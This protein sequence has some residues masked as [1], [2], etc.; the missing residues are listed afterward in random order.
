MEIQEDKYYNKS[1]HIETQQNILSECKSMSSN[2]YEEDDEDNEDED[3]DECEDEND[4][5]DS[6][7]EEIKRDEE[8]T[9]GQKKR[10]RKPKIKEIDD[11]EKIPKKRG[12]KPKEKVYSVKELPKTFFE[13]NKNEMLILHLPIKSVDTITNTS[14]DIKS[15][16]NYSLYD[17]NQDNYKINNEHLL[18]T[19]IDLLDEKN[20]NFLEYEMEEK[21]DKNVDDYKPNKM[22]KKNLKNI[23]Y[24]F[25][26]A[27]NEKKWPE[28]TNIYCW[29]C[30]HPFQDMPCA[31]PEN[32]SKE[33]FYVFG[34]FCSFN[35]TAAYN[36]SKNDEN[37]WERYTLLNLMYKK[38]F[39]SNFV[40]I[41][42]APVRESLKIFGGYL[43]IEEFRENCLKNDKTLLLI[44]PPL[45]SII[46]KIEENMSYKNNKTNNS[47]VNENIL[48]KTHTSLKLKRN[49]PITNPNNTLQSFM[50]LKII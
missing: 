16:A 4:E 15:D 27:N 22:F 48:N 23:M 10:G 49:K 50:D 1:L 44:K 33:K 20:N 31:L 25:V 19:Q 18:Q 17:E 36:F 9:V 26:N 41:S 35:C 5:E 37:M 3:E 28:T 8:V 11:N 21:K 38:L 40:K 13:E 2:V 43:S 45:I 24:Q 39:H 6:K 7:Q 14:P 32:Y 29:W 46:P 47:L 34:C 12:R 42:C 30:C